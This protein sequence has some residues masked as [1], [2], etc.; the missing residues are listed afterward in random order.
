MHELRNTEKQKVGGSANNG[1]GDSR[2][3]S[4]DEKARCSGP[5]E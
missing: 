2:L 4:A 5:N 3:S 1:I